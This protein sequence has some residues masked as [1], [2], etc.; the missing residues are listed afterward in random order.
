MTVLTWTDA[1]A[2][3]LPAM[4]H[5]HREFVDL[6][7]T[8]ARAPDDALLDAWAAL[9]DH[10]DHH[11][12]QE[13]RWMRQTGFAPVNC[14]TTQHSVVLGVMREGLALGRSGRLDVVRQMASELALWFPQ[15]AQIMDAALALHLRSVGFD[16]ASGGLACPERLPAAQISGCGSGS[17]S[18]ASVAQT[19]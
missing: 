3:D 18:P 12:A 4:D 17:C 9:V 1:L 10:T 6:L 8:V 11:F 14:H 2:L 19:G 15:H 16:I 13:D 5:T 7:E